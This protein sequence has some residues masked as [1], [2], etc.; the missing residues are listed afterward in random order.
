MLTGFC[1]KC[2]ASLPLAA[3]A[4]AA[5]FGGQKIC[6]ACRKRGSR[7]D[8]A[9]FSRPAIQK[10]SAAANASRAA[11][12]VAAPTATVRKPA[13]PPAKPSVPAEKFI[14]KKTF[15]PP[16]AGSTWV[17]PAV[18]VAAVSCDGCG[19]AFAPSH[20]DEGRIVR[21][22][23][24]ILCAV[25][26]AR[27]AAP[28]L[29]AAPPP[30]K[31]KS[32]PQPNSK[33]ALKNAARVARPAFDSAKRWICAACHKTLGRDAIGRG[34][35]RLLRGRLICAA[36]VKKSAG[37]FAPIRACRPHI[38]AAA[39]VFGLALT[40][41][42]GHVLFLAGLASTVAVLV[43][44]LGFRL[45]NIWRAALIGGGSLTLVLCLAGLSHVGQSKERQS[46]LA[47]LRQDA[48]GIETL[49]KADRFAEAQSRLPALEEKA[50]LSPEAEKIVTGIRRQL[51]A[52]AKKSYAL[53]GRA[54]TQVL[55]ALL[56]VYPEK[57]GSGEKRV[58]GIRID[59][60]K[61]CLSLLALSR[62]P[63]DKDSRATASGRDNRYRDLL[64][65]AR[66][67]L[68]LLFDHFPVFRRVELRMIFPAG[69]QTFCIDR[70]QAGALKSARDP[71]EALSPQP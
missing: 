18:A 55:M 32:K 65:E 1:E 63:P 24:K 17:I 61:L 34:A 44:V 23:G 5:S 62:P 47:A 71:A 14:S 43:G 69:S 48:A 31:P 54:E 66:G 38:L 29:P 12:A 36:C 67:C 46:A 16:R 37:W 41:F 70:E 42:P 49:L 60:D 2:G 9:S 39:S 20:F 7:P 13:R 11:G 28:P 4:G 10:A 22:G 35:G 64:Q 15:A 68:V 19:Q 27:A 53:A 21:A 8:L 40:I 57:N 25:C 59:G 50:G 3:G 33:I 52:W 26:Q 58:R 30:V 6:V 51:D 56:S 45:E